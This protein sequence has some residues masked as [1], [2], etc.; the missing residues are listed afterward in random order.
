[1]SCR[2]NRS[3]AAAHFEHLGV[4]LGEQHGEHARIIGEGDPLVDGADLHA[5]NP[6]LIVSGHN[7]VRLAEVLDT[8][9][10]PWMRRGVVGTVSSGMEHV[11]RV[12]A[13]GVAQRP[14]H[15]LSWDTRC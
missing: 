2:C 3:A 13:R 1:M 7:G 14:G 12:R 6:R 5:D 9:L 4:G 15:L 10:G 8:G 11:L